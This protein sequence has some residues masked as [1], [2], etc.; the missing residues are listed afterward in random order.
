MPIYEFECEN[1]GETF[2]TLLLSRSNEVSCPHCGG[3]NLKRVMSI[4]AFSAGGRFRS[5]A[6]S[7]GGCSGCSATSCAG[8]K[9]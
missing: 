2:E 8:C 4:C 1:C 5:T 7:S 6:S 3:R 9:P